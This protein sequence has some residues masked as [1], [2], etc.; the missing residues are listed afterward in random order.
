MVTVSVVILSIKGEY[1]PRGD[2]VGCECDKSIYV[3]QVGGQG[4]GLDGGGRLSQHQET[5]KADWEFEC[6]CWGP[7]YPLQL[8]GGKGPHGGSCVWRQDSA[9]LTPSFFLLPPSLSTSLGNH[10]PSH[11]ALCYLALKWLLG[12]KTSSGYQETSNEQYF[13]FI[14]DSPSVCHGPMR[15][16]RVKQFS[17]S[18]LV[19]NSHSYGRVYVKYHEGG[20]TGHVSVSESCNYRLSCKAYR[21]IA[22][23]QLNELSDVGTL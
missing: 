14:T 2:A 1:P 13:F 21:Y 22:T 8:T 6:S 11:S 5:L 17:L 12:N 19:N 23:W 15:T 10:R 4:A 9:T 20:D 18:C 7:H 16:E 3:I